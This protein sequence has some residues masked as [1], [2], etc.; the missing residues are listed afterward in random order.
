MY[1]SLLLI[2]GVCFCAPTVFS[3]ALPPPELRVKYAGQALAALER[4]LQ[5]FEQDAQDLNV[6]GVYG[7]RLAQGQ[8]NALHEIFTS[9]SRNDARLTDSKHYVRSLSDQIDRIANRSLTAIASQ[10]T[11]Y[12]HRFALVTSRPFQ[13][14]YEPRTVQ[15]H[16]IDKGV[17]NGSFDEDVSDAC[18]AELL[19]ST[20]RPDATQCSVTQPCWEMMTAP[21]GTDYRLTHQL[22][23]FLVAKSIG[24]L[25]HRTVSDR[26]NKKLRYL[27]DRFCSNIYQD[28]TANID[29]SD[30][31][32]LLLEEM[33]LCAIVGFEEFLRVDWLQTILSWQ[34]SEYG[35][36]SSAVDSPTKSKR[37]LL[38]EQEMSHDCLSHKSGLAS[39]VLAAY[40][41][42]Y[43]Q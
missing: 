21:G 14:D 36:F 30:N 9:P 43:L 40:A 5:F 31:Q 17:R 4:L 34:S 16:L 35:C 10:S 27:E 18:F 15:A 23:W 2:V 1:I 26:A 22:L 12:L 28:A 8:L 7:L 13:I 6:D 25:D 11:F 39:G 42:A 19:G 3:S 32:D 24:C 38:V 41:R 29:N 37:H 33:L 20:D